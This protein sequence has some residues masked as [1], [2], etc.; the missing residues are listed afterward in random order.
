MSRFGVSLTMHVSDIPKRLGNTRTI[1]LLGFSLVAMVVFGFV[2]ANVD[3]VRLSEALASANNANTTLRAENAQLLTVQNQLRV[4]LELAKLHAEQLKNELVI[5]QEQVF[6]LQQ[7][8]AFYQHVIAPE[9]SQ[10]GF[11]IDGLE[12]VASAGTNYFKGSMVLLQQRAVNAVVKGTLQLEITG[13]QD[14]RH[15]VLHSSQDEFLPEGEIP[16]GFKYFQ[17][18][19]FYLQLPEGFVPETLRFTTSVFQYNRKRGDYERQYNWQD[20]LTV[21]Q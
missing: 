10:D 9:T 13:S 16:Y 15:T 8:K 17:A 20:V 6:A 18:V 19:T 2:L 4:E 12:L 11:F 3:R 5:Q 21:T 14:G 1:I 7:D